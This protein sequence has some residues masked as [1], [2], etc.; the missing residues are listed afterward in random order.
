MSNSFWPY[1]LQLPGFPVLHC[2][3]KFA[4]THVH[5]VSDGYLT[6]SST[7]MPFS[8]CPQSFQV[9][10]S[11]P[12]SQLFASGGES[13]GASGSA[14]V[15]PMNIQGWFP[16][17]LTGWI[18]LQSRGLSS[19][20]SSTTTWKLVNAGHIHLTNICLQMR[21]SPE[22]SRSVVTDSLQP[23]GLQNTRLPCP[24]P[25]PG[26]YSNSHPSRHWCHPTISSSVVP[27]SSCLLSFPAS[28]LF[29]WVSSLHQVAKVWPKH[30]LR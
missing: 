5:W 3:L 29:K 7:A 19:I 20:F 13:I 15:L 9:S 30:L 2:L 8:S 12:T 25:T 21:A 6:I 16:L 24:S 18:S 22:F 23:H 28:G 14:S 17:V 27:F 10:G 11:F 26:A 4:Q 1:E